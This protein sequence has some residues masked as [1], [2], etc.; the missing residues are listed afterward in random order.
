MPTSTVPKTPKIGTEHT[1]PHFC[2]CETGGQT[3]CGDLKNEREM[4]EALMKSSE[5]C[6]E[7]FWLKPKS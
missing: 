4:R 3:G 2:H 6:G 5:A 1:P 7:R